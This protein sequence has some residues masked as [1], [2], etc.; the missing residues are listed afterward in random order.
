[1]SDDE[2]WRHIDQQRADLADFLETLTADQWAA[3]SL[4]TGW[5]VRDVAVHVTQSAAP[6][7][8]FA[9]Q[10][11]RSGFRFNAMV[12]Q[13]ARRTPAHPR[14]SWRRCGG[15]SAVADGRR[16]RPSPIH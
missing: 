13:A 15:W 1:M 4:C 11:V 7:A 16:G 10:A 2:I 12:A 3:P 6:W 5:T 9:V 8:T 14:R